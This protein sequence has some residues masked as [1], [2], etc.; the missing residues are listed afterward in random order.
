MSPTFHVELAV[1]FG[2]MN[3]LRRTM[4][5]LSRLESGLKVGDIDLPEM[6]ANERTCALKK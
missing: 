4:S 2:S 1:G 3:L 5:L 6:E